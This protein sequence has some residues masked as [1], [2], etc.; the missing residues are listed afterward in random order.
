VL[1]FDKKTRSGL[2]IGLFSSSTF[3]KTWKFSFEE[4]QFA[5]FRQAVVVLL[6]P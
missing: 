2:P 3:Q 6:P 5:F 4:E 1:L